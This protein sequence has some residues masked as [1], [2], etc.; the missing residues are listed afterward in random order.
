MNLKKFLVPFLTMFLAIGVGVNLVS[1]SKPNN[2]SSS[3]SVADKTLLSIEVTTP[4][5]K[6]IYTDGE[7]FDPTGMVV[8]G[9]Y[10]D[11]SREEVTGY[12]YSPTKLKFGDKEVTITYKKRKVTVSVTVK[13]ILVTDL[14][15]AN[16]S[17]TLHKNETKSIQANVVPVNASQ[18]GLT[19]STSDATV[20]SVSANGE[21]R[22]V[23]VGTATITVSTVGKNESGSVISKT[24]NVEVLKTNVSSLNIAQNTISLNLSSE[25]PH[26][27]AQITYDISPA[28]ADENG[29]TYVSNKPE[30]ASVNSSGL[31]TANSVGEAEIT[32]TTVGVDD[33]NQHLSEKVTV[34]VTNF[35][36]AVEFR[37]S[38]GSILKGI[39]TDE[40]T[41][42]DIPD[43]DL[44][45][46]KKGS[47]EQFAY[48][49][50]GFDKP[51]ASYD[52]TKQIYN[53]VYEGTKLTIERAYLTVE[54]AGQN[55]Q[56]IYFVYEGHTK[57]Y[58]T[59]SLK[60]KVTFKF[61]VLGEWN[62]WTNCPQDLEISA[63]GAWTAVNDISDLPIG[64]EQY[65]TRIDWD[66]LT[67]VEPKPLYREDILR[68]RHNAI[69]GEIYEDSKIG[70]DW[71]GVFPDNYADATKDIRGLPDTMSE[72]EKIE[73]YKE[74]V[75]VT[76]IGYDIEYSTDPIV[77]DAS[78][79]IR[80]SIPG[81]GLLCF[82]GIADSR[83]VTMN[84]A[85]LVKVEGKVYFRVYGQKEGFDEFKCWYDI[86][87]NSYYMYKSY[88]PAHWA[89]VFEVS[90]SQGVI[91]EEDNFHFDIPLSDIEY[92]FYDDCEF[93][94]FS[95]HIWNTKNYDGKG[96]PNK[97]TDV[98]EGAVVSDSK[99]QYQLVKDSTYTW[100]NL[101]YKVS[102]LSA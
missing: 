88:D 35:N 25:Q 65:Y 50:R 85:E 18:K 52:G 56:K 92:S 15:I 41:N 67:N 82:S 91:I 36:Y 24:V 57:G 86:Q 19:Y 62:E 30:I 44:A 10:D 79:T 101:C 21:V 93:L 74:A 4:P 76:W 73:A 102:K 11:E 97:W 81:Y 77:I 8:Q 59:E 37:N 3:I 84:S 96:D 69:T 9:I 78:H 75:P 70:N 14:E 53:A 60:G 34:N 43:Y 12:T 66:D 48:I 32:V 99:Y 40:I 17:I 16:P 28:N 90:Q 95:F 22:G 38:D 64:N 54:N 58:T 29:V 51:F 94:A 61:W 23:K 46:P 26:P 49:F 83:K 98:G 5:N 27:T 42:G 68:Y 20:A 6:V 39:K 72:E 33:N 80:L 45:A 31:I 7:S 1:C 100:G 13:E 71:D 55:N 2:S 47:D 89:T 63:D 87:E